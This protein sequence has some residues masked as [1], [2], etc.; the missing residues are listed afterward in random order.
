MRVLAGLGLSVWTA[1][2]GV[3]SAEGNPVVVELFTSQG[4]SSC[5]PA[6]ALLHE[7]ADREDVIALALHV[8][9]WDYIGWAD[10]FA[11][12]E[13]TKRQ[14]GYA[15]AAGARSIYTPQLVI[16]GQDHVI[17]AR[18]MELSESIRAHAA[19]DTGVRVSVNRDGDQL[20]I[21]GAATPARAETLVVQIVRYTP[22]ASVDIRRGENAGRT[23]SYSHVVSSW[24]LIGTWDARS[25]FVETVAVTGDQPVVV[26]IQQEN[27][28][29]ILAAA[30][31]R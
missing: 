21:E 7:L 2:T 12:P 1:L 9:Y 26:L 10:T 8:D 5:P 25:S 18:A 6:D 29:A 17:G 11:S 30:E 31:V 22:E 27:T 3:A 19:A 4:C 24:E 16:N 23:I 15:A 14:R 28:G 20:V 13:H